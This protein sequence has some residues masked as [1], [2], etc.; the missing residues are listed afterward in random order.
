MSDSDEGVRELSQR[1]RC[2]GGM[3]CGAT[4][5]TTPESGYADPDRTYEGPELGWVP[6]QREPRL[7]IFEDPPRFNPFAPQEIQTPGWTWKTFEDDPRLPGNE[8]LLPERPPIL[9]PRLRPIVP[10][11]PIIPRVISTSEYVPDP[12]SPPAPEPE[13]IDL[14]SPPKN[15]PTGQE[16]IRTIPCKLRTALPTSLSLILD[17][18]YLS[19]VQ[20]QLTFDQWLGLLCTL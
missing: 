11:E 3:D 8:R 5:P 19:L 17:R 16:P 2:C 12:P 9:G 10:I 7:P 6:Y 14:T 4:P 13:L 18:L 1:C 15:D 20:P